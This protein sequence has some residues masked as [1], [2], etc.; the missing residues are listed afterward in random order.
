[1]DSDAAPFVSSPNWSAW[2]EGKWSQY[3]T[4]ITNETS[5]RPMESNR[6]RLF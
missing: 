6:K 1:M 3:T 2:F 4:G 5:I